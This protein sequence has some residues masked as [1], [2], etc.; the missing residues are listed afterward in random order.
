MARRQSDT[1]A[2]KRAATMAGRHAKRFKRM[3]KRIKPPRGRRVMGGSGRKIDGDGDRQMA[4]A[5]PLSKAA[6]IRRQKRLGRRSAIVAGHGKTDGRRR[7]F[8]VAPE[9][10]ITD[11]V[12]ATNGGEIASRL[13]TRHGR[14]P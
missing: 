8:V 1:R 2:A 13:F 6:Q 9:V 11:H 5:A 7:G 14:L 3:N 10:R 4:R 12:G